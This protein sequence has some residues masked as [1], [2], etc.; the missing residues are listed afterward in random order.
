G[1]NYLSPI[2]HTASTTS[3][4]GFTLD[5]FTGKLTFTPLTN[6]ISPMAIKVEQ[7][8]PDSTGK[9]VKTSEI[10]RDLT[11]VII[12]CPTNNSPVLNA[13]NGD[14]SNYYVCAGNPININFNTSDADA[15]DSVYFSYMLSMKNASFTATK[16]KKWNTGKFSWT[17]GKADIQR[18]PHQ[19]TLTAYDDAGPITGKAEKVYFVYVIGTRPEITIKQEDKG[20]GYMALTPEGADTSAITSYTWQINGAITKNKT[21]VFQAKKNGIYPVK[22]FT[23][24]KAGCESIFADTIKISYLPEINLGKDTTVCPG[25]SFQINKSANTAYTYKWQPS[26]TISN[27]KN[28][29]PIIKPLASEDYVVEV[30]DVNGCTSTDTFKVTVADLNFSLTKDTTVCINKAFNLAVKGSKGITYKWSPSTGLPN[31]NDTVI[32]IYPKQTTT[33]MV[34]ATNALG[35]TRTDS[36]KVT[37]S[38]ANADAGNDVSI[39]RGETGTTLI[40]SGGYYYSWLNNRGD[41]LSKTKQL[42]VNPPV[43]EEFYLHVDDSL[44]CQT[45]IDNITVYVSTLPLEIIRDTTIC[46]GDTIMLWSD[47]GDIFQWNKDSTLIKGDTKTPTVFPT[48]NTTYTVTIYDTT[49]QCSDTRS[50]KISVNTDCVWPGDANKDGIVNHLDVLEIGVGY[51]TS[52]PYRVDGTRNWKSAI[53]IDWNKDTYN[54]INYKHLDCNGDGNIDAADNFVISDNYG[55]TR[56]STYKNKL[57]EPANNRPIFFGFEKDT[58]YA[59]DIIHAT[60]KLGDSNNIITNAYG[61]GYSYSYSNNK[62]VARTFSFS[63]VCD[64]ICTSN[65]F[66]LKSVKNYASENM[67]EASI[68]RT[69]QINKA[70]KGKLADIQFILQDSTHNYAAKGEWIYLNLLQTKL[71]DAAGKEYSLNSANDSA[72]VLRSKH[73]NIGFTE[74][75]SIFG[76]VHIWPN[77]AQNFITIQSDKIITGEIY[78]INAL[79]QLVEK[80]NMQNQQILT[81]D[82]KHYAAGVYMMNLNTPGNQVYRYK[83]IIIK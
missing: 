78:I 66:V 5:K 28:P 22:L 29:S 75:Q 16:N 9:M 23:V 12:G 14:V 30:L 34:T 77:P 6:E 31:P 35:C 7:Y 15:T 63:T 48:Q 43:T 83:F 51:G 17:P 4:G 47:G 19:I 72:L 56:V 32:T 40:G 81:I 65:D 57:P 62:T 79:G 80:L 42:F 60:L 3:C 39:C 25:T 53:V 44:R 52:G 37:V 67:T 69:D 58:F 18:A 13:A 74:T 59:G 49:K 2:S 11:F 61:I 38:T 73:T 54:N 36:V 71:V 41:T 24:N 20:C 68:V 21:A 46:E 26:N 10:V 76:Q 82:T 50:V 33:Y 64:A 70:A 1:K 8:H 55:K 27:D 45:S